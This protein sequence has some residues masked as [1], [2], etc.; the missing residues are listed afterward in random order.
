M[1]TTYQVTFPDAG[2]YNLFARIR[3]GSDGF[4]DDSFFY[5]RGF[6]EK[7]DTASVDWVFIN[8]LASAGFSDSAAVVDGAGTIGAQ[9]WK[10]VNLTK[11]TYS[12]VPGDSFYVSMDSLTKTFQIGSR[13]DGLD[14][15]KLAFGKSNLYF[16]VG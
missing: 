15:D 2:Y 14:I 5:G 10:W 16:T 4:N 9:V 3:V 8:G 1:I 13:E 7:D 6:G 12:G 11:N